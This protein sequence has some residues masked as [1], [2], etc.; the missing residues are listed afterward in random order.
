MGRT[1]I[2]YPYFFNQ[3]Y[4][5]TKEDRIVKSSRENLLNNA[6]TLADINYPY[7]MKYLDPSASEFMVCGI[8]S[9]FATAKEA[10]AINELIKNSF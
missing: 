4:R 2:A 7:T 5:Y 9:C 8:N 10:N 1:P 3:V 6:K